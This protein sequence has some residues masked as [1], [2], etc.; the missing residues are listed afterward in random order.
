M[1]ELSLA[2]S[3]VEIVQQH[4]PRATLP[5]V[6]S[7]G[8]RVGVASGV[9]PESLAFAYQ[10][11]VSESQLAGSQLCCEIIPFRIRCNH[12]LAITESDKGF[13]VCEQCESGDTTILSGAEL[14]VLTIELADPG[15][16]P[17]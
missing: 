15:V 9:V 14:D 17:Q 11:L 3:I 8:V 13:A 16:E 10:S 5:N 1:H 12:C 7:V 6:R 2:Q 4:V